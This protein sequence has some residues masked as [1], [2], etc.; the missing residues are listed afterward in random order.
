MTDRNVP[1]ANTVGDA[2]PAA[3]SD[4][5]ERLVGPSDTLRRLGRN[6]LAS[7]GMAILV[8]IVIGAVFAPILAPDDSLKMSSSEILLG[9]TWAHPFGT[10]EFGRD[11]FS[12]IL[13]G[14][15]ISLLVS[16]ASVGVAASVGTA[17]GIAGSFY[18]QI[19][20]EV[21][22]RVL[23]VVFAFPSVLLALGIVAMLGPS[24]P[25]LIVAIAIVYMP[26]FG[27]LSRSAVLSVREREYIEAARRPGGLSPGTSCRTSPRP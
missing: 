5:P 1:L 12:R 9:P 7:V 23:E 14:A 17:L 20:D 4:Q 3:V 15:R 21:I 22:S 13:W 16:V 8:I 18:G 10:D 25:N 19:V 6:R 27:R 24:S 11:L 26:V 2:F